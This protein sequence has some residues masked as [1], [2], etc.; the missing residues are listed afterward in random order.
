[1]LSRTYQAPDGATPIEAQLMS[2]GGFLQGLAGMMMNPA[3]LAAQP[4][5]KRVRV[6]RETGVVTYDFERKSAQLVLDLGGKATRDARR[7][8]RRQRRPTRGPGP[9]LGPEKGQGASGRLRRRAT[10]G[11]G[12]WS[13]RSWVGT[14]VMAAGRR[15][16]RVCRAG[17]APPGGAAG[18]IQYIRESVRILDRSGLETSA[19]GCYRVV[20]DEHARLLDH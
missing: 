3:M 2:G 18:L 5:A 10:P 1:M 14:D 8:G 12:K 7:Q 19:C 4:N 13:Q 17:S 9:A 6:G 15:G 20:R 11:L 16:S